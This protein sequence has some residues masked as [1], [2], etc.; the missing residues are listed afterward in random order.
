MV[1]LSPEQAAFLEH[2]PNHCARILAGPG[3]GKSFTSVAYLEKVT[4]ENPN[5]RVGY[6][7]FTRAA[8]AEFAR[9]MNDSGLSA[10][11]GQPPKTMHGLALGILLVHQSSRIPYPLR[12]PDS[13]ET[14]QLIHMDISRLL[15][16]KGFA[17]A[18]PRVV[19][20]LERE[21]AANFES[22]GGTTLPIASE[23]PELVSAYRG[24]WR[25]HRMSYGYTL[26]SELPYQAGGVLEDIDESDLGL[27]L[28]IVDEYQDLNNADQQ[29][30]QALAGRGI[31]IIAI[32][33]DDQSI[34]SWRNA[35]PDGIRQ[36]NTTFST[37]YDYPLSVS[38][39]CGGQ[40]LAVANSVIEQ[41][42]DRPWKTRLT[43]SDRAPNTAFHY[44][45]FKSNVSEAKGVA[46][47]VAARVAGGVDPSDIAVL[48]RSSLPV[49][50]KELEP[51]LQAL[52]ISM[53][54][55]TDLKATLA[56]RGIRTALAMGQLA[57]NL[58]DSLSW[59][60]LIA[61]TPGIGNT[62]IDYVYQSDTQGSFA[63]RLFTL[64]AQGF[65]GYRGRNKFTALMDAT[66]QGVSAASTSG[67]PQGEGGWA[68]WLVDLV[69]RDLFVEDAL[70]LYLAVGDQIGIQEGLARF[71]KTSSNHHSGI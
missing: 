34:Y 32:G 11:G 25:E 50:V 41:D 2:P 35:A 46:Q 18:T 49:W 69:G 66:L 6:V 57:Q 30:L 33:D 63:T 52:G 7:T 20:D 5:L 51:R 61:V 10:L 62:A 64:H 42:S 9:K 45:R 39:R 4:T 26:L 29:V 53:A 48:V 1:R 24:V 68:G 31:T 27:D 17:D 44:L 19:V 36:F 37:E 40:A 70:T 28:V 14:T 59:R 65:E 55:P 12:I 3:T 56:D 71:V 21:L 8:T 13:W 16:V 38:Q 43:A 58:R 54:P 23:Q 60:A 15:R 47:I 22:L 67:V